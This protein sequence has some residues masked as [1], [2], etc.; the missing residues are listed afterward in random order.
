MQRIVRHSE[1]DLT[2]LICLEWQISAVLVDGATC[3]PTKPW[4]ISIVIF[5]CNVLSL[6][7]SC[8]QLYDQA[9]GTPTCRQNRINLTCWGTE[10]TCTKLQEPYVLQI[11]EKCSVLYIAFWSLF[12]FNLGLKLLDGC[13]AWAWL[14]PLGPKHCDR[15]IDVINDNVGIATKQQRPIADRIT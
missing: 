15:N 10:W 12:L 4:W 5:R 8:F 7:V 11:S 14:G 9:A 13:Q 1:Q 2:V 6:D 3:R